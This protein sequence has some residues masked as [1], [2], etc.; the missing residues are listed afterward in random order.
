MVFENNHFP[1][2]G[3]GVLQNINLSP[4]GKK[5]YVINAKGLGSCAVFQEGRLNDSTRQPMVL[6]EQF[7]AEDLGDRPVRPTT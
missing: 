3:G 6:S 2:P 4:D 1:L 7:V 5:L